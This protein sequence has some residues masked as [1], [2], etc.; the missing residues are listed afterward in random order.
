MNCV[1][2]PTKALADPAELDRAL[3]TSL[4]SGFAAAAN[5]QNPSVFQVIFINYWSD[6]MWSVV[7][8]YLAM[9]RKL[10]IEN[11]SEIYPIMNKSYY[12]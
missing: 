3:A 12:K 2:V 1:I 11:I 4:T 9:I 5:L 10:L 7:Q 6:E 8:T